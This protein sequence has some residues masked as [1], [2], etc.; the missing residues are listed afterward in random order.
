MTIEALLKEKINRLSTVPDEFLDAV[1]K[2]EKQFYERL[3]R[4]IG[5]LET[6]EGKFV[7]SKKN[8]AKLADIESQ[9]KNLFLDTD[10][11]GQVKKFLKEFDEQ[12]VINKKYFAKTFPGMEVPQIAGELLKKKKET[13]ANLLLGDNLDAQF[14][15][16]LKAQVELAVTSQA[17]F[18]ETLTSIQK[19]VTGD[20]E[21]DSKILQYSKQ[22]AHDSFAVSDR[23]Y[24]KIV[25]DELGAEW[26][27]WSGNT[28]PTSRS[29]CIENHNKFFH[30]KEIEEMADKD[31]SGKM[32]GTNS[33]TIFVTAG[34]WSCR[35]SILPVSVASVPAEVI[36]RAKKKGYYVPA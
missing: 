24:T 18:S 31:W 17:S 19:I 12:A 34:G 14:I 36:E 25:S 33:E 15:N 22:I 16:P 11:K 29:I 1:S 32:E 9:L 3:L 23:A 21:V 4:L 7:L 5:E 6:S 28:I 30:R 10:F 27:K 20:G 8:L 35:H 26:F 2:T 13:V